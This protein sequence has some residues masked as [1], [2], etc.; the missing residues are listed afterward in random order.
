M[1]III[2][3]LIIL[4]IAITVIVLLLLYRHNKLKDAYLAIC[5]GLWIGGFC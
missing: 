1:G 2:G 4:G 3:S 5:Y